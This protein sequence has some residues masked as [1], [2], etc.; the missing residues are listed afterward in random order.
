MDDARCGRTRVAGVE[1]VRRGSS[2]L[3]LLGV[4]RVTFV[5]AL[6]GCGARYEWQCDLDTFFYCACPLG[7]VRLSLCGNTSSEVVRNLFPPSL[8]ATRFL[9]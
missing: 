4:N 6:H 2:A 5:V 1:A 3:A 8:P 9:G 7:T